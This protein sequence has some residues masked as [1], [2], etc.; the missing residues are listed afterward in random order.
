MLYRGTPEDHDLLNVGRAI[1][2]EKDHRFR[3]T[4]MAVK[5]LPT[6]WEVLGRKI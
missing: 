2:N 1:F 4:N 6:R 3:V 5:D